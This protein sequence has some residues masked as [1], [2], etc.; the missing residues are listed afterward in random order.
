VVEDDWILKFTENQETDLQADWNE[1]DRVYM[2]QPVTQTL[3]L[4]AVPD[5]GRN[6]P[7][8]FEQMPPPES[9]PEEDEA[10]VFPQYSPLELT[11]SAAEVRA[12]GHWEDGY[13]TVEFRRDRHTP[14]EHIYD[15]IFNRLVQFSVHVFDQTDRIDEVAES[16]R[17]F[18]QF[19]PEESTLVVQD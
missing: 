15:T 4:R 12:K 16:P 19:L 13:W 10:Q 6:F 5:G 1:M 18:L 11:G 8:F 17:L 9:A 2:L 7:P 3:Y 14:A